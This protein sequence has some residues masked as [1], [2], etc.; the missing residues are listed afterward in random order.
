MFYDKNPTPY[1]NLVPK[2]RY[3]NLLFR[4]EMLKLGFE[5][6]EAAKNLVVMCSRDILFY[7]NTF[8]WT[9][10][11]RESNNFKRQ[12]PFITYEYQDEAILE[13][14]KAIEDGHDIFTDKSRDM[15]ASWVYLTVYE[16]LWHFQSMMSFLM[17]SRKEDY[18]DQTGNPKSLFWKI[19]YIHKKQPKWL[20]PNIERTKLH[21]L[22]LDNGSVIDGESTN[23][24]AGR[25]DRRT[26]VLLDEFAAVED[27]L[28]ILSATADVTK[29]RIF[30]STYEGAANAFYEVSRWPNIKKLSFHWSKHPDKSIGLYRVDPKTKNIDIIDKEWH[31]KNRYNFVLD[32]GYY[33]GLHSPWYDYECKRR[34]VQEIKEQLD[35]DPRGSSSTFFDFSMI[36]KYIDAVTREPLHTLRIF[37]NSNDPRDYS[38]KKDELGKLDIYIPL[39]PNLTPLKPY[40][41]CVGCDISSGTGASNSVLVGYDEK[42][43]EKVFEFVHPYLKPYELAQYAV[44]I[45]T[46]FN[47]ESEALIIWEANGPGREFGDT[48]IKIGWENIYYR[49]DDTKI[50]AR[51]TTI[52]G[53][54]QTPDAKKLLLG[55]YRRCLETHDIKNYSKRGVMECR[56]YIYEKNGSVRHSKQLRLDDASGARD[57]H[58]DI[59][60][61]DALACKILEELYYENNNIIDNLPREIDYEPGSPWDRHN[62]YLNNNK[63]SD[64]WQN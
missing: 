43:R 38:I 54:W 14:V 42:S 41:L 31:S 25:G 26:S 63:D 36:D 46:Y 11:P 21:I 64:G 51:Q 48:L 53:Y 19:D 28:S 3:E 45:C 22:N 13:T 7:I 47:E 50:D 15:G 24:R 52:P 62:E 56:E 10:D 16:A 9:Y 33:N 40:H 49:T 30:N 2:T 55:N 5:S 27:G 29:C 57:N 37:V 23:K 34:T 44:A 60:I 61:G 8:V 18:V 35:M 32:H 39:D 4:K 20:L 1:Y 12:N 6:S 59:V 17:M 58:G